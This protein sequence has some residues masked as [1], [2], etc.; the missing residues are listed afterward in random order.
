M[1]RMLLIPLSWSQ[2]DSAL[3]EGRSSHPPPAN[4]R[5]DCRHTDAAWFGYHPHN[6]LTPGPL[7]AQALHQ[8]CSRGRTKRVEGL[9]VSKCRADVTV[10][11][12]GYVIYAMLFDLPLH[13]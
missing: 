2:A 9:G 1:I 11:R 10:A 3:V 5:T 8:R 12:A 6:S 13:G 7:A 4:V